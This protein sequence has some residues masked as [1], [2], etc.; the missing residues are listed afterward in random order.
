MVITELLPHWLA[1]S[2][3][4]FLTPAP[5]TPWGFPPLLSRS[6]CCQGCPFLPPVQVILARGLHLQSGKTPP[7][8]P[9]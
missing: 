4:E 1:Q 2:P 3:K 5:A 9:S 6:C 7:F 8:I